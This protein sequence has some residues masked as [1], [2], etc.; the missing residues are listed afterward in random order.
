M[1]IMR[2]LK[3]QG[4]S[5]IFIT[6]KLKKSSR[7][8]DVITVMRLV[9]SGH[10]DAAE[11]QRSSPRDHDGGSRRQPRRP[12]E[13]LDVTNLF[14]QDDR[15]LTGVRS[16]LRVLLRDPR[17]R[18]GPRKRA[19]EL[20]E[21]LTGLRR[22][23]AGSVLLNGTELVGRSVRDVLNAGVGHVPEDRQRHG[24]VLTLSIADNLVLDS[25]IV[26]S[27]SRVGSKLKG[28]PENGKKRI[29]EY[30]IRAQG[31]DEPL[32]ASGRE[33]NKRS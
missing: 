30:D 10:D 27:T 19:T 9:R 13:G 2:T 32:S 5:I 22:A 6:H 18:R 23:T 29:A 4:K 33:P 1:V 21:A 15:G 25:W 16:L 8:A 14:V 12:R 7:S 24:L 28:D 26:P 3:S 17:V 31:E 11:N 20:V